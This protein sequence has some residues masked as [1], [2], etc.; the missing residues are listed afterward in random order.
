[1]VEQTNAHDS[2][3]DDNDS[4]LIVYSDLQIQADGPEQLGCKRNLT[5]YAWCA[6][7]LWNSREKPAPYSSVHQVVSC[8]SWYPEDFS[9]LQSA[10]KERVNIVIH[11]H[12]LG[13][14]CRDRGHDDHNFLPMVDNP[15]PGASGFL[16]G[17]DTVSAQTGSLAY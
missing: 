1:M 10:I 7:R 13:R 2:A 8:F 11:V 17:V 6:R 16:K 3:T 14:I 15:V 12:S 5:T 4:G 9:Y